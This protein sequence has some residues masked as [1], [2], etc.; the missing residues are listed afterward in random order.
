MIRT[1][2]THSSSPVF[3]SSSFYEQS[4]TCEQSLVAHY[5]Y[6]HISRHRGVHADR[7]VAACTVWTVFSFVSSTHSA[8]TVKTLPVSVK[9]ANKQTH[10]HTHYTHT[11]EHTQRHCCWMFH[12]ERLSFGLRFRQNQTN[13]CCLIQAVL[14]K[15]YRETVIWASGFLFLRKRH[16]NVFP[17]FLLSVRRPVTS[18]V[19][20]KE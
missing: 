11:C 18:L 15:K 13:C 17:A 19:A 5:F 20:V 2:N 9:L 1:L 16:F 6:Y 8:D 4:L 3:R 12:S 14:C 10:Y 7:Q